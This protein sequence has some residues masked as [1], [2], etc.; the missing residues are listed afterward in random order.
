MAANGKPVSDQ[1]MS[2]GASGIAFDF[3]SEAMNQL[4][5]RA[6]GEGIYGV[7]AEGKT[8]F[9]NPAAERMLRWK[10]EELI[11]REIHPIVHH[12][13]HDGRHYPDHDCPIYAAFRDGAVQQVDGEV[14]W[15]KDGTPVW[16][17]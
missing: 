16:V 6:A 8:T 12:T 7:N 9:V 1:K 10:A 3:S 17:E 5:L 4:I 11:G 2:K 13:H 15:R 14:F